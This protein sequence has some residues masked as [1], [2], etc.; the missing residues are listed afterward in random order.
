MLPGLQYKDTYK[1]FVGF[2]C[3]NFTVQDVVQLHVLTMIN[4]C[5]RG[6]VPPGARFDPFGPQG[7]EPRSDL[8]GWGRPNPDHL[9]PPGY[10]DMFM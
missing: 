9:P 10:D 5:F 8:W 7:P 2:A 3:C 4:Y 1:H 6:S